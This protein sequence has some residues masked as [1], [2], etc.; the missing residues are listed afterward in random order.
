MF[1]HPIAEGRSVPW[2]Q[3]LTLNTPQCHRL[4]APAVQSQADF[5]RWNLQ[6]AQ[7]DFAGCGLL[8][9]LFHDRDSSFS[10]RLVIDAQIPHDWCHLGFV[11]L[12]QSF[13][14]F[15]C[16]FVSGNECCLLGLTWRPRCKSLPRKSL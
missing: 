3:A 7:L 12:Q 14:F 10:G 15:L 5:E 1:C 4:N 2:S 16:G 11:V 13:E 6:A 9:A 8:D